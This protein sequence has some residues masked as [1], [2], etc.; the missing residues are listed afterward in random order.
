MGVCWVI[1]WALWGSRGASKV[2][3]STPTQKSSVW[4][5]L[6]G[7]CWPNAGL[8]FLF[9][10]GFWCILE[11]SWAY[12]VPIGGYVRAILGRVGPFG[13]LSWK[14]KGVFIWG[15]QLDPTWTR[16]FW[17]YVGPF[18]G[19]VG[20]RLGQL[21]EYVGYHCPLPL[22]QRSPYDL[23]LAHHWLNIAPQTGG[24]IFTVKNSFEPL[25]SP[26]NSF[27]SGFQTS[28]LESLMDKNS[29]RQNMHDKMFFFEKIFDLCKDWVGNMF[30]P[31]LGVRG[32]NVRPFEV[33]VWP[34]TPK[35]QSLIG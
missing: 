31:P 22:A 29:E 23:T 12:I 7:L 20:P 24:Y 5:S 33:Y 1:W 26:P 14:P 3:I 2:K 9:Y 30:E 25:H 11:P 10:A 4:G 15:L 6:L 28:S 13:G 16:F 21:L 19:Y 17:S 32:A 27:Q 35:A 34:R 8:M 18:G